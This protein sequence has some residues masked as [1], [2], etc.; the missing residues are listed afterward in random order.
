MNSNK[1]DMALML[2]AVTLA[3]AYTFYKIRGK[4]NNKVS[5]KSIPQEKTSIEPIVEKF[6]SSSS[7]PSILNILQPLNANGVDIL[8]FF[9]SQSGTAEAL[10]HR[11]SR[12]L[13]ELFATTK[14]SGGGNIKIHVLDPDLYDLIELTSIPQAYR[15]NNQI[16]LGFIVAT[17]GDGAPTDNFENFYDLISNGVGRGDSDPSKIALEDFDQSLLSN[18]LKNNVE[19]NDE[20]LGLDGLPYFVFGLGNSQYYHFG[21]ISK[22][23]DIQLSRFGAKRIVRREI[24]DE[25]DDIDATFDE[26]FSSE[27]VPEL[28][29][30]IGLTEDDVLIDSAARRE[31]PF[32]SEYSVNISYQPDLDELKSYK[33][34]ISLGKGIRTFSAKKIENETNVAY[35]GVLDDEIMIDSCLLNSR[36]SKIK[37]DNKYPFYAKVV[38]AK[39]L[40][41]NSSDA[42]VISDNETFDF[43]KLEQSID[44]EL[45]AEDSA[46]IT[47]VPDD[48]G[49]NSDSDDGI[50]EYDDDVDR[51]RKLNHW[52]PDTHKLLSDK[53]DKTEIP[54]NFSNSKKEIECKRECIF[55]EFELPLD[56][57]ITYRTGDHVGIYAPNRRYDVDRCLRVLT[58]RGVHYDNDVLSAIEPHHLI[59]ICKLDEEDDLNRS[60]FSKFGC[61]ITIKDLFTYYLDITSPITIAQL[62]ILAKFATDE[63][64]KQ[65]LFIAIDDI[66]IG[67]KWISKKG[68][69][70]HLHDGSIAHTVSEGFYSVIDI[71][72]MF[73]S[74]NTLPLSVIIIDVLPRIQTRFYSI[75]SSSV[76][77]PSK[78][79]ITASVVRYCVRQRH[80]KDLTKL[81]LNTADEN[82]ENRSM[83]RV[84]R[85]HTTSHIDYICNWIENHKTS[86]GQSDD[87]GD[88]SRATKI[89]RANEL[90]PIYLPIFIRPSKFKPAPSYRPVI[91]IGP[92]TGVA[93]FRAFIQERYNQTKKEFTV[94]DTILFYGCRNHNEDYLYKEEFE[95]LKQDP[96][97]GSQFYLNVAFSR[98]RTQPKKYVQDLIDEQCEQV[99]NAIVRD[100]GYIFVCGD[101]SNMSKAVMQ[102]LIEIFVS[103]NHFS[104]IEESTKYMRKIR[105]QGRFQE[106][107]W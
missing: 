13:N 14:T 77:S 42:F 34:E 47:S 79:A 3:S 20:S 95:I 103:C 2:C 31:M 90:D 67:D 84:K 101:A 85:G 32:E 7:Q 75:S 33:G 49:D 4:D 74:I 106:D 57:G 81:L 11:L 58:S 88:Y 60:Q 36:N 64:Q 82:V 26:W 76:V 6:C 1:F 24:G 104:T 37:Y 19:N 92:G 73:D 38:S 86:V 28:L 51:M 68:D 27:L 94:G 50:Y 8:I 98:D 71:L 100:K 78:V 54:Y 17:Y 89:F 9:G 107:V 80:G 70:V 5:D 29:F 65:A 61:P 53:Y 99:A 62:E 10:S 83:L 12:S 56:Q 44:D 25:E 48:N 87:T 16:V 41:T 59:N 102:K 40:Y 72:E 91:M 45:A 66:E 69:R 43:D 18:R 21:I 35:K 22:R 23:L 46:L 15:N 93:P 55:M 97:F 30:T 39:R 63:E 105:Q 52:D 96:Q